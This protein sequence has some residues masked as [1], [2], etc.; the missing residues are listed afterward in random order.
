MSHAVLSIYNA[1]MLKATYLGKVTPENS[2]SLIY[3]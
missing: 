3:Q 1:L 2:V